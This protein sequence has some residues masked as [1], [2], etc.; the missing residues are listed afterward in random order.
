MLV[1]SIDLTVFNKIIQCALIFFKK[2]F[3]PYLFGL[4]NFSCCLSIYFIYFALKI[5]EFI[6]IS[7][8][9]TINLAAPK[10]P[11]K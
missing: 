9:N 6:T 1:K 10:H 8:R 11:L 7:L 4:Y 5:V 3:S 2:W